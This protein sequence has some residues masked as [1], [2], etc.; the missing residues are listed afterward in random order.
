MLDATTFDELRIGLATADDIRGWSYGEVKKPETINYRTLKPEKDGLFGEQIFGPSRDWECACGKYKRVRFKGIVCER[1]GVEVT[2]SSVRRERMGHIELAAPVTHIWYFKG[3]PSRL[4]YLLDMAPKDLEKVIYFAAYMVISVD[5]DARHR[6]LATQENNIRLELKTLGDRRD[7]K[8]AERMAKLEEELAALE[9]EG[10]KAD[11]KKKV[12][13][14]AEKEMTLTRKGADEAIAKLERVWEDFRTLEVGALRPEDDVFHELQDRFGQYFEAHMGAESIKRRLETFDLNAEAENLHL[15]ISEGKGQR[16]IRAIKRL[17]VVNSFLETGMSP[18]AMVLDVVPVI[19]PELRPMVQLDGGRFATSDLNDLYRRVINRNNRLR[20][21]IDLGAPEIIVNNEK[22][23]LQE[24][25]DA[26]F[27]NGRRGRPVTGTG[28]RA[29]KSLSDMLKGKQGR[30]RQNLLGKR[31]DYSGRSVIIVGPQLKLHQ[32]GLPKQMAL[33]LFKPFVIKRLIDLGHS[34]NIKAAKRAVERTRPEVWDVLEEI[35]RERPVLLNRAPTLH[36]LGIQAFEPQLVEGKAIQLHPLVCAAFNADFDGDQM[37]VHLPLSVEAQAEARV[38]MLASNNILKPSDGRPVTLPSQDMIIGL[39]HLTT[40]KEGA[41]GEGRAFGSVGEAVLAKD[42]G[43]LDLQA[44]VRIRIPGLSFLEGEAPEGYERH[45]LV[46]ASLGQAIFNDALPKGY[47]FVRGVADKGKLSQIVNKLAEEYP[48]VETAATLDRIKDAGFHWAT[49]SGV[50]VA[51]SDVITPPEKADIVASYEKKAAKVQSQ[52]DKGLTTDAERRQELIQIW[53]AA[54]DEV[55]AAMMEHFP[56]D[57]TINRMVTSGAR[58]N[59]LQIRNIAGMR[60]LVNNP[61]G[62]LI[63]RP[64]ISSYRE[65]LSV[66][67]YFIATHGTRKGLADTALRTADSGYLTRR[68]VDVSQDVII[69]EQDCGTSK[70]LELPIAAVNSQGVL[71]RDP[72]VENS[73]F[74]RTLASDVVSESGEVV[75]SAGEDVGDVL[76]DKL[77]EA[78]VETIKVRSVLTCDSAVGVCAQCYGRSL[79]TG[80]TVDIGEAVGIIAAQSI[81]EPG[82]QLTMR[83]FHLAS[84]GDITQGLPRVQELFEART[85]KGASPIA[86]ADGRITIEETEKA[87]KVILTPDNGDEEVVYPVLKRATLLVEDGQHVTVGQPLQVGTLDP[88]EV[89]RVMGAREVQKYL[90]GGVQGVYRSQGVPIHDKHIEV[91]VRQMLRK[92]T[93]VDHGDTALLPGEMV[94]LK[95]YQQINREAVSEGKRPASGRPELMGITKASLATE[96][97][98]SAASFQ[99]TTRVLTQAAMEGKRD[100]LVGLKENVIIGKL[101]PAGTGLSKY[102]NITVEATEEAKSERYPNRIF[103]SDGAYA[104]GDFGY[105]DFDAFSTDDIT[106]GT[107]N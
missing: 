49:R 40:V 61:K 65:G 88:K 12:K 43:T 26:L 7:A 9:A 27:D 90:V 3:V 50:T 63:P 83:T 20:R 57:N 89:M 47:P 91:I 22:R 42:E 46:D 81:G 18:A 38:L 37:A 51:L 60:G 75:A 56:E 93:V 106:P 105:V 70:G 94:D 10:A 74:A 28:N 8:I 104:D 53:T 59:W 24:A 64:I 17:K 99:E 5:E 35:I 52:Y 45:G 97:W 95:R 11:A 67:E 62:E 31:V 107:Y 29:L 25:V 98:L 82:T 16:K 1:C 32:C 101:I 34:Q 6:D 77:V 19:P 87:K 96:S 15:Q 48:K 58:G 54:T 68:L 33:E 100:P 4:G 2:K 102:R 30:F 80:K 78:G 73:V 76:I 41:L 44:K 86:E 92:V 79:A 13:D 55:Q 36:R 14:A 23:M 103:A 21:L 39:H 71:T 84:A 72:N 85:P 69:R 66:A